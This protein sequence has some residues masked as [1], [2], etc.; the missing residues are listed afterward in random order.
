MWAR[1]VVATLLSIGL[2]P[3]NAQDRSENDPKGKTVQVTVGNV[4]LD[5]PLGY[6]FEKTLWNEGKWPVPK[7]TRSVEKRPITIVAHINGMQP[8]SPALDADFRSGGVRTTRILIRGDYNK[9]WLKNSI[10]SSPLL[11]IVAS[12]E[13]LPNLVAYTRSPS[14][15]RSE[16]IYLQS[17]VP[18]RPYF[19]IRCSRLTAAIKCGVM[20]DYREDLVI[21]YSLPVALLA[22]WKS[23]HADVVRLLDSFQSK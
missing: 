10:G 11:E 6:F 16:V 9:N 13:K 7:P 5:I 21:A 19:E 15:P 14:S 22:D 3:C 1:L 12:K 4:D 18:Q 2:A 17:A 20:F 23:V 8:W